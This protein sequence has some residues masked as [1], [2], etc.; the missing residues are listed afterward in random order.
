LATT[1]HRGMRQVLKP[2]A[3]IIVAV[4][5]CFGVKLRALRVMISGD[6]LRQTI[7]ALFLLLF[8]GVAAFGQTVPP[9]SIRVVMDNNYPPFVFQDSDG[10]LEGMLIDQ[11]HIWEKKTGIKVEIHAMDWGDALRL[12]KAGEFDVIDTLFKTRERTAFFDFSKPYA[13]IEVAIFFDKDI[14]GITDL[15]S[16]QGFPV[17]IKAGDAAGD[18]LKQNGITTVLHFNNY[19]T[20]IEAAQQ[21][22]VNVFVVDAPPA[23]Y[24]L[25]KLNLENEFRRSAPVNVGEFHRAVKKGNTALLRTVEA[26][27]A[28]ITPAELKEIEDKWYGA[29]LNGNFKWRYLGYVAASTLLLVLA[30]LGWNRALRKRVKNRTAALKESESRLRALLDHIPDWVWLK[31]ADSRY[32]TANA[33][34]AEA[35]KCSTETLPGRKDTDLWPAEDA[36][37]YVAEDQLVLQSGQSQRLLQKVT[38]AQG[39]IR[40]LETVKAPV[41]NAA[42]TISGTVGIARDITERK[43]TEEQLKASFKEIGDLK[44]ALDEHA[45]VAITDSQGKITH[46]N[47][48]FCAISK[49]SREELLGQ[50][51]RI[52]NSGYHPKEFIRDLWTTIAR[53][54]VWKG[55]IK[56]KAKD[57]SFYWVDTTI[58]PFLNEDGKSHQYVAIRA[59]ITERKRTEQRLVALSSM[60]QELSA[61]KTAEEAAEIIFHVADQFF[62]WDSCSL[63]LYEAGTNRMRHVMDLDTVDGRRVSFAPTYNNTEPSPLAFRI[64][65]SGAE[66]IL[67]KEPYT[68]SDGI[69][70]GDTTRPSA[71][72]MLVPLHDS[73][74]VI[75]VLSIQSYAPNAYTA[76]DLNL[77]QS[78]GDHCG[79][80]LTRVQATEALR[81]SELKFRQLTENINE[82]FWISNPLNTQILYISPAYEK[83]WG[84]TCESLLQS[85]LSWLDAIHPEDRQRV[86]EAAMTKQTQG[87]YDETYRILRPDGSQRWVRDRAFPL[88]NAANEVERVVGTAE[89]ITKERILE[90]QFRQSQKMEAI[91]QLAGGVAHDFNNIL[92]VILMQAGLLKAKENL[93]PADLESATEIEKAAER[94]AN[95]TRQLLLFGRRQAMQLRDLELNDVISHTNRMLQRILGE[96][97]QMQFKYAPQPL[98][99]HADAGMMD[100]VLMNLTVNSRDAMPNG[101]LLVIET[102]AVEFDELAAAQSPQARPGSF[103]CLSVS[104]TGCG[105]PPEILPRIFEPF[106]TTKDVGK[107]TGL[108]LATI[109]SI[110]QQH[111]GWV[112]VYSEV[113]RGT[114]FRVYLPRLTM[115]ADESS[116]RPTLASIR[117]GDEIILLA[118]DDPSLRASVRD[119]LTRLGYCVLEASTGIKAL[120]VWKQHRHDIRL[121]LTDLVMPDGMNG[122]EL[123]GRLLRDNPRLKVI[124]TSGYSA[125]IDDNDFPLEECVNFLAK[126]FEAHK[127]AKTVRTLLDAR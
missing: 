20:I 92:A 35:V 36:R 8:T 67:R 13:R 114:A 29:T 23:L 18:L 85:P 42:G 3:A 38:D 27:F 113:G 125:D 82:V 101:G 28:A 4:V 127:L 74:K 45:I 17:A 96:H 94:A 53:G 63:D 25:N 87:K 57:G 54:K 86:H 1:V 14:A 100:Q 102:S 52:I 51:H 59:D 43:R 73:S 81:E 121:L 41:H 95:L 117:G 37:Q 116:A 120:E 118:E 98:F 76:R 88:H 9:R 34:Y 122:K 40:W 75:G 15:K 83:I 103:V 105:I 68:M 60:G 10:T 47:D 123:A 24:Y 46:V 31:D 84:R 109:F 11:W 61:A 115:T 2:P 7:P 93:S 72:I 5:V 22:K 65:E 104:D 78:V 21:H 80:A 71:S 56:N 39:K 90:E 12:M 19:E 89:D 30:L 124:Y 99:I 108:G 77:L 126:P 62:G 32:V 111:Q 44:A 55:E 97:I 16:L 64:I 69:P 6:C 48:K 91:G 66:L 50:D 119:A 33:P 107:G 49:Y 26:G 106:F 112:N 70:F 58:V 110:V 79:G